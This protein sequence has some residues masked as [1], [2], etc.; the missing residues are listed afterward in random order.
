[1]RLVINQSGTNV[2]TKGFLEVR[3][4]FIPEP[5]DKTYRRYHIRVPIIPEGG[6]PGAVDWMGHP[7]DRDHFNQ[8]VANLPTIWRTNPALCHFIK[9]PETIKAVDLKDFISKVFTPKVVTTIDNYMS[10]PD[11]IHYISP[12]MRDKGILEKKVVQTSDR[13]DLVDSVN[14]V[15]RLL[16]PIKIESSGEIDLLERGSIE[17]GND[18]IIRDDSFNGGFT[19]ITTGGP[20]NG[21]G[22]L[23]TLKIYLD[24]AFENGT[25]VKIGTFSGSAPNY[26]PRD[27]EV[28]GNVTKGS[29]HTATGKSCD[30]QTD[31][32]IGYFQ[33]GTDVGRIEYSWAGGSASHYKSGDQFG[34]GQQEYT[35]YTNGNASLYGEGEEVAVGQQLFTL[36]N[37]MGY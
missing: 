31:D 7:V 33:D 12:Y 15:L 13:I 29:V 22:S 20:A 6:Y 34:A 30:V 36:I 2:T 37:E 17:I 24:D 3:C 14:K 35:F 18:V 27:V 19:L 8:W 16:T 11:N 25:G 26:T 10:L 23:S 21:T 5:S 4:D 28:I 32:V 9:V 1:M